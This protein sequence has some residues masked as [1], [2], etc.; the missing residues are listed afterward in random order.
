MSFIARV[1]MAARARQMSAT[2][3][4]LRL[5]SIFTVGMLGIAGVTGTNPFTIRLA[6]A[7]TVWTFIPTDGLAADADRAGLTTDARYL[8]Q[9][10]K[11]LVSFADD[12]A[13]ACGAPA[14]DLT[15]LG[16]FDPRDR[17]IHLLSTPGPEMRDLQAVTAAHELLHAAWY[18]MSDA[19]RDHLSRML[20][21]QWGVLSADPSFASQ[22]AAYRHSRRDDFVN[23]LHSVLATDAPRLRPELESYYRRY[24]TD[25]ENLV[26][27]SAA[28]T[29]AFERAVS[30]GN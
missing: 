29:A 8:F 1:R 14:G 9:A 30:R 3:Q 15:L 27:M 5:V 4:F 13:V 22:M 10:S 23:E 28:S 12:L 21:S 20:W 26:R 16:C 18:R 7:V 17:S 2:R 6:D 25:R 19:E 11:P 24:F